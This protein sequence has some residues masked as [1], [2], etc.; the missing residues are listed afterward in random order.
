MENKNCVKTLED[1]AKAT[2]DHRAITIPGTVWEKPKP[3]S[4]ILHL[5]GVI[6]LSLLRQGIYLYN[7]G[8]K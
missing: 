3:A 6:I 7:K 8:G 5:P 4:V 2:E 1:L